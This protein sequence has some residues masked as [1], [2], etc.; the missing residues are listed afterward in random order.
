MIESEATNSSDGIGMAEGCVPDDPLNDKEIGDES[1]SHMPSVLETEAA[2]VGD[3]SVSL[4]L[5]SRGGHRCASA[6]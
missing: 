6:D 4:S 1:K 5:G 3:D 2:G